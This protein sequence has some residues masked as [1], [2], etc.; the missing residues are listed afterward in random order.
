MMMWGV[1][2]R[3]YPGCDVSGDAHVVRRTEAGLLAAVIDGLGHGPKAAE[4]A[5]KAVSLLSGWSGAAPAQVM[6]MVDAGL[7]GT[8]GAVLSL[9]LLTGTTLTWLG[10]GNVSGVVLRVNGRREHLHTP[11]GI[12]G[13]R[14]P[15]LYPASLTVAAGDLLVLATDGMRQGFVEAIDIN[16]PPQV[17]AESVLRSHSRQHDDVLLLIGRISV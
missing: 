14:L 3:A 7:R 13:Y 12:V 17:N 5:Q 8:R 2:A 9:A 1:A 4:P 10:V 6:Q 11:G 16:A 15:T